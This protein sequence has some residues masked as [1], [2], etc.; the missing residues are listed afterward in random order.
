MS[1]YT[2]THVGGVYHSN[3]TVTNGRSLCIFA[4]SV[5]VL[6][7][8]YCLYVIVN[9]PIIPYARGMEL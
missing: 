3:M 5:R 4:S 1:T 2:E 6:R 9:I 8:C 7:L